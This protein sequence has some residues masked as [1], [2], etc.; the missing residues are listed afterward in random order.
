VAQGAKVLMAPAKKTYIDMQYDSTTHIGLHWAAYIEVDENY[1]WDPATYVP[2]VTKENV[3]GIE[4]P[5]WAETITKLEDIEYLMFPRLPGVA[6]IGWTPSSLRNWD[7]YKFR[8]AKH[9]K[10]FEEMG[11]NYYKSPRVPW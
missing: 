8:L 6:E 3:I 9:A 5:M 4:A 1:N 10:F 2:G 7:E 11:I